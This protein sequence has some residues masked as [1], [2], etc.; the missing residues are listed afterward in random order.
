MDS[1]NIE[2]QLALNHAANAV[3]K[4][5]T[6]SNP[7]DIL[8]IELVMHQL[9]LAIS[10]VQRVNNGQSKAQNPV[11][12]LALMKKP[13]CEWLPLSLEERLVDGFGVTA[14]AQDWVAEHGNE[15]EATL[16]QDQMLQVMSR[17]RSRKNGDQLYSRFRENLISSPVVSIEKAREILLPTG[18]NLTQVFEDIPSTCLDKNSTHYF[19]C[20]VCYWPM[21]RHENRFQCSGSRCFS[22]GAQF[23]FVEDRLSPLGD[24][25]APTPE[26]ADAMLRLKH[27]FWRYTLLPGLIELD[28]KLRLEQ[29]DGVR[30]LLWPNLDQYDLL[31][32]IGEGKLK[33]DIKDWV[34][35]LALAKAINNDLNTQALIYVVP[36]DRRNQVRILQENCSSLKHLQ[37]M[38]VSQL[39]KTVKQII[40]EQEAPF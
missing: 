29:L 26:S 21:K 1:P 35:A 11:E 17:L 27:G 10:W 36:D 12:F 7:P 14:F 37:F 2:S 23:S 15:S 6:M 31:V 33:I 8:D 30:V 28:L 32:Q 34:N 16:I 9:S 13:I 4:W 38:S 20:P 5:Y 18:L 25:K 40:A 19:P 22:R 39:L 24:L 3:L